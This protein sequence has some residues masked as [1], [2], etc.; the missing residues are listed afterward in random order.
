MK[1]QSTEQREAAQQWLK[2]LIDKVPQRT[3][4]NIS[5]EQELSFQ[6][7]KPQETTFSLEKQAFNEPQTSHD[8]LRKIVSNIKSP[9]IDNRSKFLFTVQSVL[10]I[11]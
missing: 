9:K 3:I 11:V 1:F 7:L 2:K 4:S 6:N 8:N 10:Q 5:T